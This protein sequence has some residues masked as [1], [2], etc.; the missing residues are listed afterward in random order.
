MFVETWGQRKQVLNA[1]LDVSSPFMLI[2]GHF[3]QS[4]AYLHIPYLQSNISIHLESFPTT[5]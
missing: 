3:W 4:F 2:W 1:T 5:W